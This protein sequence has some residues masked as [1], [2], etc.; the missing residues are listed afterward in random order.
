[1]GT[2][3]DAAPGRRGKATPK[4]EDHKKGPSA[5]L[6]MQQR[7]GNRAVAPGGVASTLEWIRQHDSECYDSVS[8]L[9]GRFVPDQAG[10]G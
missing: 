6:A 3:R 4:L 9:V 2:V 1:M 7:A 8:D 10:P 5:L